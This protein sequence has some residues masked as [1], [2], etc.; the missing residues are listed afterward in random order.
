V[1]VGQ[2]AD[3]IARSVC[4]SKFIAILGTIRCTI[5]CATLVYGVTSYS[6]PLKSHILEKLTSISLY[7]QEISHVGNNVI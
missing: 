3:A 4:V 6:K 1:S 2:V 5:G 7:R